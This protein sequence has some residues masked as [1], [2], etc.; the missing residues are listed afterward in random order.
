MT[1]G[2]GLDDWYPL[3]LSAAIEQQTAI[4]VSLFDQELVV[5]RSVDGSVQLWED[6]C[7][8]RGTRLSLGFVRGNALHCLYHGWAYSAQG[9]CTGIPAH[10]GLVP[11]SGARIRSFGCVE[12]SGLIWGR[13][14]AETA[15]H[16]EQAWSAFH[17]HAVPVRSIACHR[18]ADKIHG[19]LSTFQVP[20]F[21][22]QA[23]AQIQ[24]TVQHAG[25]VVSVDA[26]CDTGAEET[27]H[28]G[29]QPAGRDTTI[30]HALVAGPD[31]GDR[32]AAIRH[33]YSR[34]LERFRWMVENQG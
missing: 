2:F 1:S 9:L 32:P 34:W 31:A 17:G 15:R 5:W 20:P 28:L 3:A 22:A 7:A 21:G 16:P 8:H 27:L 25:A 14:G 29:L 11:P 13:I 30:L 10:P 23:G 19:R 12:R 18:S 4:P 33:H 24:Y 6:R 26:A